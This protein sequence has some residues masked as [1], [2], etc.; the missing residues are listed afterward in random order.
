MTFLGFCFLFV[1]AY[2]TP[3]HCICL[4]INS[5]IHP[6]K[7]TIHHSMTASICQSMT[8]SILKLWCLWGKLCKSFHNPP[9]QCVL[10]EASVLYPLFSYEYIQALREQPPAY[11]M[12]QGLMFMTTGHDRIPARWLWHKDPWQH[13]IACQR[14]AGPCHL[15]A[16]SAYVQSPTALRELAVTCPIGFPW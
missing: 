1:I 2:V 13:S 5:S 9:E 3:V 11:S 14:L 15:A 16:T 6:G 8:P 10:P 4:F 7:W 12:V